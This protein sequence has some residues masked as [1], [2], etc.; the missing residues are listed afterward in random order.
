MIK[1]QHVVKMVHIQ[2]GIYKLIKCYIVI[3]YVTF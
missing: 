1:W 3:K 2:Y